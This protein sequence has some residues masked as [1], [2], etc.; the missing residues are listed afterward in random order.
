[1]MVRRGFP[2]RGLLAALAGLVVAFSG[3]CEGEQGGTSQ[4][5]VKAQ[6]AASSQWAKEKADHPKSGR[7]TG[8]AEKKAESGQRGAINSPG[9]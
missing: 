9:S 1:M 8:K 7:V 6:E 4:Q 3:G 5:V 2:S